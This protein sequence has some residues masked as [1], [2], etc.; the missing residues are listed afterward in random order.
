MSKIEVKIFAE[1]VAGKIK[2]YLPEEYQ[3][4]TCGIMESQKNNGV[5][6]IS[7]NFHMPGSKTSPMIYMESFYDEIRN[8]K[9]LDLV[10]E[11]IA[12]NAMAAM[13]GKVMPDTLD[14]QSYD[15]IKE[16]LKIGLVNKKANKLVLCAR[17][18]IDV[19]DLAVICKIEVPQ[20]DSRISATINVTYEMMSERWG[21]E[22][23]ELFQRAAENTLRDQ[24]PMLMEMDGAVCWQEGS[25]MPENL[26]KADQVP[27][28]DCPMYVMTNQFT[29]NGAVAMLYPEVLERMCGLFPEGYYILPSS[30]HDL[31]IIPKSV[32]MTPK[33]LGE[34]VRDINKVA[35]IREEVLSDRIYEYDKVKGRIF[36]VPESMDK[37]RE[38]ER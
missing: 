31:V 8:G 2:E 28:T 1:G 22:K 3:N 20:E 10:M 29:R 21:I 16:Y 6:C 25:I 38:A 26:L 14:L 15:S 17:P 12:L 35:V 37:G 23:K 32:S 24:P 27:N 33:E 18:H 7:V 11:E 5:G 19:E 36:Q 9:P 4:V 34:M 13:P 30:I